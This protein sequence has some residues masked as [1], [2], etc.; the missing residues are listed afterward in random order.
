[1]AWLAVAFLGV[2]LLI[3]AFAYRQVGD[4]KL[5]LSKKGPLKAL[6]YGGLGGYLL[7]AFMIFWGLQMLGLPLSGF[8]ARPE[9]LLPLSYTPFVAYALWTLVVANRY[10]VI[11]ALPLSATGFLLPVMV[12]PLLDVAGGGMSYRYAFF[13]ALGLALLLMPVTVLQYGRYLSRHGAD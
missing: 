4:F 3:Q 10:A 8:L 7:W 5:A 1:M 2:V 9:V 6:L 11:F 13:L 12:A